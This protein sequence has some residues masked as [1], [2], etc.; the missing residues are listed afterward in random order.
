[1]FAVCANLGRPPVGFV[2]G[3][4]RA[5]GR[6]LAGRC[7]TVYIG[8]MVMRVKPSD[9]DPSHPA[10][11]ELEQ[12]RRFAN[13]R[14]LYRD[15]DLLEDREQAAAVL[16]DLGLLPATERLSAR[17]LE[18][19]RNLRTVV[20]MFLIDDEAFPTKQS[21]ALDLRMVLHAE[22]RI[23]VEAIQRGL[24][25]RL[26]DL[27]LELYVA[28]RTGALRRLKACANPDCRWLFWDTSRPATGRWC[29]MQVCGG[30]HKARAY[31]A[32]RKQPT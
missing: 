5:G 15:R 12:V 6:C 32:R 30:Q 16:R 25:G 18:R 26:T 24:W 22:R 1:V 14:D 8:L 2:P 13:T 29:S 11:G 23:D 27:C 4:R 7:V 20:R 28:E 19:V 3:R 9:W 21:P 10:P 31:R 17:E